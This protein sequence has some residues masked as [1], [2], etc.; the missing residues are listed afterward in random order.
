MDE[1][2][3]RFEYKGN[4]FQPKKFAKGGMIEHGL[5]IGD[6]IIDTFQDDIFIHNNGE[7]FQI[8]LNKGTR[9]KLS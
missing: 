6:K 3:D 4:K 7:K 2:K 9:V 5:K 8:N 1:Y